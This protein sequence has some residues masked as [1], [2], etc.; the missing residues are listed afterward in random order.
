MGVLYLLSGL[1]VFFVVLHYVEYIDDF[2][3]R[4]A[5]MREVFLTY[6]PN[7]IPEIIRLTSPLAVFLSAVYLTGK[8]SQQLQIA[9]LQLSG[10]SLYRFML[11]YVLSAI[12][13]SGFMFWFNG[14]IVPVT[15]RT[16]ITFEQK[17]LKNKQ[18][19]LDLNDIHRQNSPE[20]I[21]TVGF[22]DRHSMTAHRVA[23][24]YFGTSDGVSD[25]IDAQRMVWVDSTDT[26]MMENVIRRQ[27][28]AGMPIQRVEIASMDTTLKI[29]PRDLAR[30]EREV[31]SMTIPEA[32]NYIDAL[33]RSGAN[34][35]GQSMVGFHNK[36]SYPL[37]NLIVVLIAVPL[38]SV[39][40][41]GGQAVHIGMGLFVS[42]LYLAVM[43]L[44]EPFGYSNEISPLIAAWLPHAL[45][46]L[47][48]IAMVQN[49]RK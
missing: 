24:H 1:I 49:A 15:N 40:R 19:K 33:L 32:Q 47:V 8:L 29:F 20:S 37:A 10:V 46:F 7:Y 16:V 36:F 23:L 6:Y 44:V 43:K 45:F 12:L 21:L 4:G 25:R 17:Y 27:F 34:N 5:S 2:M 26:W 41:R 18:R 39:R 9:A 13:I 31:E 35:T 3:D 22:Y 28:E 14:W 38:A 11:P 42:F 48:G 30:T